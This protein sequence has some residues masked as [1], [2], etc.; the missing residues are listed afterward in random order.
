MMQYRAITSLHVRVPANHV[1]YVQY[2][3]E[4]RTTSRNHVAA[5]EPRIEL[6]SS[7]RG[8]GSRN[9]PRIGFAPRVRAARVRAVRVRATNPGSGSARIG[10]ARIGFVPGA[11]SPPERVR[12]P[13]PDPT[14]PGSVPAQR[15]PD[16][17]R[18]AD[19]VRATNPG[20]GSAR[21]GF[22]AQRT[23]DRVRAG[24]ATN[25]GSGSGSDRARDPAKDSPIPRASVSTRGKFL[26]T[27]TIIYPYYY[28][29]ERD[30]RVPA[31][32]GLVVGPL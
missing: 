23:P 9:E 29:S 18:G 21:I 2:P 28:G 20:S 27:I 7:S 5:N 17:V 22:G 30:K 31:R 14:N 12:D 1:R 10:F 24:S 3:D 4:Y 13:G 32:I 15:T 25:P 6:G 19:R 11:G 26:Q 8:S 16:R